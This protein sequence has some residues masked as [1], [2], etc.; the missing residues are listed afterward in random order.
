MAAVPHVLVV[1]TA[2]DAA[3]DAVVRCLEKRGTRVTR[4]NTEAYPYEET[5]SISFSDEGVAVSWG[6]IGALWYRRVRSPAKPD[7]M[8]PA[9]HEYCCHEAQGFLVGSV[10]AMGLPTM[11]DPARVW[12]AENKLF[13][14]RVARDI[15]LRAPR[16]VVTNEP[17][18][19]SN[20]YGSTGGAMIVKPLRSGY[21][22]V[23]GEERAV[24]TNRVLKEHLERVETARLCPA[25]YQEL[26]DKACDVRVTVVGDRLFVA[27]IDSQS[28]RDAMVDWRRTSNP[29][30]PHREAV[31]PDQVAAQVR[32]LMQQLGLAF[33]A[34]DFVR[35]KSGQYFFLEVN[36]NGQWL[37]L[38]DFLDFRISE[39]VAAWLYDAALAV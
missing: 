10:L 34:L 26:V 28:D 22:D 36:P 37:W 20:F 32:I 33:G 30:L 14:L 25:I 13:Q 17:S 19:I 2:V 4:L 12:T 21:V 38:E 39:S 31:L 3:T 23:D 27:E 6:A 11:S 9:I 24:F 5:S 29:R 18:T 16:T 35:S 1:S 7:V 15:G 8:A